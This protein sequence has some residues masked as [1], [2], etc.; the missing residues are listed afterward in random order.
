MRRIATLLLLI[1]L[2]QLA[3]TLPVHA[4]GKLAAVVLTCDLPRYREAHRAFVKTLAQR[5]YDQSNLEIIV[6]SP[7]P[8]PISWANS[9]RKFKAL[10]ANLIITYGAPATLSAIRESVDIP[11]LFIDVY[12]P[13]E[14]GISRS[15]AVTGRNLTGVSS[16]VPMATLIRSYQDIRPL[17]TLGVIYSSREVGSVVQLK[18]IKRLAAQ[19]GFSVVEAN[20]S[21]PATLDAALSSL[22][23]QVDCLYVSE[24]SSGARGLEKIIHRATAAKIPVISQIPD[25][26]EKGALVT[27]EASPAEQ[28]QLAGEHAARI[29]NGKSPAQMPISTPKKVELIL[30]MR[31][32]R[33][34]DINVPFQALSAA[35]RVIK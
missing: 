21:S 28:G 11:L 27:L 2:L 5:G 12:G 32:A 25:A 9:V 4:A 24:G 1:L 14:T 17:H 7:N 8:D 20:A 33:Q 16:K 35:S 10:R 26:A 30:N 19:G 23:S 15:M 13:V 6:Q 29:L 22:L 3:G 18:E 34:L 31:T